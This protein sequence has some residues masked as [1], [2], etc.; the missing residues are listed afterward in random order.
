MQHKKTLFSPG[1]QEHPGAFLFVCVF[2]NPIL[3]RSFNYL[4]E[5]GSFFDHAEGALAMKEMGMRVQRQKEVRL[6]CDHETIGIKLKCMHNAIT[7]CSNGMNDLLLCRPL[8]LFSR[9]VALKHQPC[10]GR[11][12]LATGCLMLLRVRMHYVRRRSPFC[13][14]NARSTSGKA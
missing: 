1:Y 11:F 7:W 9:T 3:L 4:P 2:Q 14:M 8:L 5:G 6:V 10:S 13:C 12:I